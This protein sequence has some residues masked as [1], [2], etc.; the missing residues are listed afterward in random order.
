LKTERARSLRE[1]LSTKA[2]RQSQLDWLATLRTP[3]GYRLWAGS[4]PHLLPTCFAI[5][6]RELLDDLPP[7]ESN[8][9]HELSTLILA[10]QCTESG[11]FD[12]KLTQQVGPH[13]SE[14]LVLQQTQFALQALRL[15]GFR[16]KSLPFL[17]G[18][19]S[20]DCLE[21]EFDGL[22]WQNP[23]LESN[24]VMFLLYF[25]EHAQWLGLEGPWQARI[26][27]GLAWLD[28]AQN[29]SSGLWGE[30]ADTCVYNAIY[31]AY[32][33]LF[34]YLHYRGEM[35]GAKALLQHTRG[36]Q[37]REGFFAHTSGGGACEDYDCVDMLIK[38]GDDTDREALLYCADSVLKSRNQDGGYAW[39]KKASAAP[40]FL[41][42]NFKSQLGLKENRKLFLQRLRGMLPGGR[43]WRYSSLDALKC[44]MDE[45]D[46]WSTWFRN[47]ILAEI[48]DHFVGSTLSWNFREFPSLGWHRPFNQ[49]QKQTSDHT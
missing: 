48:D 34:F 12:R 11:L 5:F 3:A 39:A 38:L 44:P 33:F 42:G 47:L 23:W 16:H 14:Y 6:L 37:T 28:R 10:S 41:L 46:V 7:P 20:K 30:R 25:Y 18:F 31:G 21:R 43:T 4:E 35:P 15:L 22:N 40:L 29:P 49:T 45:S 19:E 9:A 8:E 36:L 24:R 26:D 32:H 27:D 13:G 1:T 2:Y 17:R